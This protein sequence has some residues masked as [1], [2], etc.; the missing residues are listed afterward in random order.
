MAMDAIVQALLWQ[1]VRLASMVVVALLL[2]ATP[3]IAV[4]GLSNR[5]V[6]RRA[7]S[8]QLS[9]LVRDYKH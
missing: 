6:A 3:Y 7:R 2:V 5:L 8:R 1:R 4:R 9:R